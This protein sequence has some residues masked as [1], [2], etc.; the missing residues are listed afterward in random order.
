M[1]LQYTIPETVGMS[2]QK[3]AKI[4]SVA[5][6][7]LKEKNGADCNPSSKAR[8]SHLRKEFWIPYRSKEE[9]SKKQ[10]CL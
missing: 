10:R 4:D 8:T 3:L 7:V 2:S 6:V 9:S 1:R 5:T